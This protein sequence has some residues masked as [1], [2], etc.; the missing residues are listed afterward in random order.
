MDKEIEKLNDL[1]QELYAMK[2]LGA[3]K[4]IIEKQLSKIN[5]LSKKIIEHQ[6]NDSNE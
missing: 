4:D 2:Q 1:Q 3:D 5:N 6:K